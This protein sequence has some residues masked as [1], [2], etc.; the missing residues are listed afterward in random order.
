MSQPH[1]DSAHSRMSTT[2]TV[3]VDWK[4]PIPIPAPRTLNPHPH[5]PHWRAPHRGMPRRPNGRICRTA[6]TRNS[7]VNAIRAACA[8]VAE[9]T[10]KQGAAARS[11]TCFVCARVS[12][13][14]VWA[15]R[16]HRIHLIRLTRDAHN[17]HCVLSKCWACPPVRSLTPLR[18]SQP[19]SHPLARCSM[20]NGF[21]TVHHAHGVEGAVVWCVMCV[22]FWRVAMVVWLWASYLHKCNLM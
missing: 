18:I 21:S 5:P 16:T 14:H 10:A 4:S 22:A 3:V 11:G 19:F 17:R 15:I 20:W 8:S 2:F 1:L 13:T 7:L 6:H 9:Y 12:C